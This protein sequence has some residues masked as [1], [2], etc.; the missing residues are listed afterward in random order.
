MP[1]KTALETHFSGILQMALVKFF[2]LERQAQEY[3]QKAGAFSEVEEVQNK[4]S[5]WELVTASWLHLNTNLYPI[6]RL[7]VEN[8]RECFLCTILSCQ[9]EQLG[10]KG[11]SSSFI[12]DKWQS[13]LPS[14]DTCLGKPRTPHPGKL[15]GTADSYLETLLLMTVPRKKIN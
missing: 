7:P 3:I 4:E 1:L 8:Q 12:G 10:G 13:L 14:K 2:P 6:P 11:L 5:P 9:D 15:A